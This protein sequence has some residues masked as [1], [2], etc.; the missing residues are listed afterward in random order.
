MMR[1]GNAKN[2]RLTPVLSALFR[3]AVKPKLHMET[4]PST[5]P[6]GYLNRLGVYGFGPIEPLILA[7]L[8]SED[9]ILL[10]GKAGTGKTFLLNSISEAMRL[11]HRHYNASQISFD[12]L[13]GFPY[14]EADGRSIRFLP[15]PATIWEAESVLVD[16]LNRCKPEIQNK[17]FSIIH[18]RR[19]HGLPAARLTY[20]W[21]AMNPFHFANAEDNEHY[22]GC[23]ALDPALADRFA[24]IL[25]VPDWHELSENDQLSV[26]H[27]AGEAAIS[28]DHGTLLDLV[29]RAKP[30]FREAIQSPL[31]EVTKYVQITASLLGSGGLRISPRRA[32]MLARNM[33]ALLTVADE[34]QLDLTGSGRQKLY[35]MA[36]TWSLPHRAYADQVPE[37]LIH[38]VHA[39][40]SRIS[41]TDTASAEWATRFLLTRSLSGR[42]AML[43]DETAD[44]DV[45]S[46]SAM[47]LLT[48]ES[49]ERAAAFCFAAGPLLLERRLL[50][51][52][53]LQE[54]MRIASDVLEVNA[55]MEWNEPIQEQGTQ[56]PDW[57]RCRNVL[58]QIG[59]DQ[60]HRKNRARQLFLYLIT[61][62]GGV[63]DPETLERELS[64]CF[65]VMQPFA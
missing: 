50:N 9:P 47:Q 10:I 18:E 48:G 38:S 4:T 22:E 33:T 17:F 58:E 35:R 49:P 60:S 32:R 61:R 2:V 23:E 15:T 21:A 19:I 30:R 43:T 63:Q 31:P 51:P 41:A 11:E 6:T 7:A 54:I 29:N 26:I 55:K 65:R 62:Q 53:A 3:D 44:R 28:D 13:I 42:A 37:H 14:P 59:P 20:R 8:V 5:S 24:F 39:E 36:L 25:E 57:I 1:A 46:I 52:E 56:H 45:K 27:P 34:L 64:E 12:D 40:A 16:E